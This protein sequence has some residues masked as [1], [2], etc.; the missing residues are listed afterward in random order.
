MT[1]RI[2]GLEGHL[3]IRFVDNALIAPDSW[4][5]INVDNYNNELGVDRGTSKS[6]S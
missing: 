4:N 1:H 6:H 5:N 2:S 3:T